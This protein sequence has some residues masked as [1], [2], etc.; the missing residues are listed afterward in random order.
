MHHK[1]KKHVNLNQQESS[2][3]Q[4]TSRSPFLFV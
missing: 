1:L 4:E 3:L 2:D